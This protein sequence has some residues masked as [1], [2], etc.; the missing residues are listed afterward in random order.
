MDAA[1]ALQREPLTAQAMRNVLIQYP[2]TTVNVLG[3]IYWQAAKLW[4]KRVPFVRHPRN[5]FPQN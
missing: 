1:L 2:F 4:A 5:I 3:G